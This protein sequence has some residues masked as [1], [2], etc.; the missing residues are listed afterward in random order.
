M[1][2]GGITGVTTGATGEAG[3][4]IEVTTEGAGAGGDTEAEDGDLTLC[5]GGRMTGNM[6]ST[7]RTR[8]RAAPQTR[9]TRRI[10]WK[11]S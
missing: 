4:I 10:F 6:T 11:V 3:D 7:T 9:G 1:T 2:T 5:R 8:S